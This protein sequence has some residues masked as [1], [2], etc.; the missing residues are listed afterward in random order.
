MKIV[1]SA[2]STVLCALGTVKI[3]SAI[4]CCVTYYE[5]RQ[6]YIIYDTA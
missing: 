4:G 3:F 6:I 2:I 5:S 1:Y